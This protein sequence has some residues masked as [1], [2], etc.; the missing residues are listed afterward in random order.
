M[1]RFSHS[2]SSDE[3]SIHDPVLDET[4]P[5]CLRS[6]A[7]KPAPLRIVV[8]RPPNSSWSFFAATRVFP[9]SSMVCALNASRSLPVVRNVSIV[10]FCAVTLRVRH[11]ESAVCSARMCFSTADF[12]GAHE[13]T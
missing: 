4:P 13:T 7:R 9:I 12:R 11:P 10:S 3:K 8:I 6:F 5:D 1:D 2:E